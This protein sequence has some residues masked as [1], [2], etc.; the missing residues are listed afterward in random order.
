MLQDYKNKTVCCVD[1]GLFV[2]LAEELSKYF[3]KTY[4][5]SEWRQDFPRSNDRRI[6]DGIPGVTRCNDYWEILDDVDLWIFPDIYNG[7]LQLHLQ[8]LGERVWGSRYGDELELDRKGAKEYF[9]KIG[10]PIGKYEVIIGIDKLREFLKKNDNQYVKVSLVR[11]DFETF[12]AE[13]YKLIEPRLDELEHS[14][15]VTKSIEEFIVEEEIKDAVEIGYDGYTVNGQFPTQAMMGLEVKDR[16]YIGIFEKYEEMP[17]QTRDINSKLSDTLKQYGYKN[18]FAVETRIKKDESHFVVDPC[19]RMGSPP[20][21]L[22]SMIY[23]NLPDIFWYG[24]EGKLIDPISSGKYGVEVLIYSTWAE[25]NLQAVSFPPEL[26]KN[27][28][29]RNYTVLNKEH[30]VL[31]KRTGLTGIGAIVETGNNLEETIKKIKG[32]AKYI[33]GYQVD[34]DT[35]CLDDAQKEID[36]LISFNVIKKF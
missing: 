11:G 20:G 31:P 21:E 3:G 29:L 34:V 19:C 7:G 12:H 28:K 36:K 16:G 24:A 18:F 26:K 15:G 33:K 14:L 10:I 23:T 30:Y 27:V 13:N 17:K 2:F 8:N 22:V 4:Y 5:Y 25:K 1:N 35:D 32:Y 6:G 9:K